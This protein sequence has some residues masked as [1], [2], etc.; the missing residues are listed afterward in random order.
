MTANPIDK[1][2]CQLE[3]LTESAFARLFGRHISARDIA[4][5]LLRAIEDSAINSQSQTV[6]PDRYQIRLHPAVVDGFLAEFPDF[7]M[8]MARLIRELSQAAGLQI[9]AAPQ[10]ILQ[11]DAQLSHLQARISAEHSPQTPGGTALMQPVSPALQPPAESSSAWLHIDGA[12]VVQLDQP[13][14][15][16]GRDQANDIVIA[17]GYVSRFHLQLRR[18]SGGYRLYDLNSLGGARV[19]K[20]AVA[21]QRLRNGD[22]IEIGNTS[23]VYADYSRSQIDQT[24]Q[25]SPAE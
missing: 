12:R 3:T 16:I 15:N 7:P 1:L 11:R 9:A 5:L 2:E 8:R 22:V 14:I 18:A 23:L 21:E 25:I 4:V 13:I 20:R 6:A 19:N 17:D 10:V 24:T